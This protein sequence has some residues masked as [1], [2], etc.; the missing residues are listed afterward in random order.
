M[1]SHKYSGGGWL[2]SFFVTLNLLFLSAFQRGTASNTAPFSALRGDIIAISRVK[3]EADIIEAFVRHTLH[4]ADRMI[5]S[6]S[7]SI[8]GTWDILQIL[9]DEKLP[10]HIIKDAKFAHDQSA[11]TTA[12][13]HLA[14]RH[15]PEFVMPLDADEFIQAKNRTALR[16]T[17]QNIPPTGAGQCRWKNYALSDIQDLRISERFSR[18]AKKSLYRKVVIRAPGP[19]DNDAII[20]QGNHAFQRFGKMVEQPVL[21]EC[22][23]AHFPVRSAQQLGKKALVGWLA[24]VAQFGAGTMSSFHWRELY[25]RVLSGATLNERVLAEEAYWY[26]TGREARTGDIDFVRDPPLIFPENASILF[27]EKNPLQTSQELLAFVCRTW[28]GNLKANA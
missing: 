18:R 8:D 3:N 13:Y 12:L 20:E 10:I 14:L 2:S 7:G 21:D 15:N 27:K 11:K 19:V 1:W 24:N 5:I 9:V 25:E 23:I 22:S 26:G 16:K 6:D 28:E 4:F 17:F